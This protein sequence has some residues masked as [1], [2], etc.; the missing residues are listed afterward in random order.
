MQRQQR[1]GCHETT[2]EMVELLRFFFIALIVCVHES[3]CLCMP[4]P[5]EANRG[6]EISPTL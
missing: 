5:V 4:N 3:P 1:D 2:G 6:Q